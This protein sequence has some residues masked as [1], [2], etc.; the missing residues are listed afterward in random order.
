MRLTDTAADGR[1]TQLSGDVTPDAIINDQPDD[2]E[3]HVF[4]IH[5]N[6]ML[7]TK[8]NGVA[9]EELKVRGWRKQSPPRP[10]LEVVYDDV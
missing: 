6:D 7:L 1:S 3:D 5:T 2:P 9:L 10:S 8:I 4:H